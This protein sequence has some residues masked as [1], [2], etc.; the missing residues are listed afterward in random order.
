VYADLGFE[1]D[2]RDASRRTLGVSAHRFSARF[3]GRNA[4]DYFDCG[5]DP[6]LAP[7]DTTRYPKGPRP[8]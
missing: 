7:A 5:L 6:G 1:P 2:V 4:S 3:L 8:D